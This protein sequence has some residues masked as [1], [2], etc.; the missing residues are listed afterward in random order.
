MVSERFDHIFSFKSKHSQKYSY[1]VFSRFLERSRKFWKNSEKIP[2]KF[3]GKMRKSLGK[4]W[5]EEIRG[6]RWPEDFTRNVAL[7]QTEH[8][9]SKAQ[10]SSFCF[11]GSQLNSQ[12]HWHDPKLDES[13]SHP[14]S[15]DFGIAP[16]SQKV[17]TRFLERFRENSDKILIKFW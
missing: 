14:P 15:S 9:S 10:L 2:R 4:I 8:Y 13:R 7:Q 6:T 12:W 17:I 11:T 16:D 5:S 1:K 3:S